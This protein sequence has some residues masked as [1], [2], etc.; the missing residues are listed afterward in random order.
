MLSLWIYL[1]KGLGKK[2]KPGNKNIDKK[3][4]FSEVLEQNVTENKVLSFRFLG[5]FS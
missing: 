5:L 1:R 2:K 3:S 4:Q